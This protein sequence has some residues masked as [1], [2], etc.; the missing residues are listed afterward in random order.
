MNTAEALVKL[1]E[2][3]GV[4]HIFGHPGEQILPVYRA[5]QDSSIEH[6]L[7]RHEQAGAHAASMYACSTGK[8]SVCISTASPGALNFVM[9]AATSYK[10]HV[11]ILI[12][13]GDNP[14]SERLEDRFQTFDLPSVFENV[15]VK[16]YS[17]TNAKEAIHALKEAIEIFNKE[18]TGPIHINLPKDVLNEEAPSNYLDYPVEYDPNY[19]Y[20]QLNLLKTIISS[21]KK[22]FIIAGAG[23]VWSGACLKLKEFAE[24]NNIPIATTYTARGVID[25]NN[26]INLGMVGLRG[27]AMSNYAYLNSDLILVLGSRLSE[28]TTALTKDL[29]DFQQKIVH[30]NID[31]HVLKGRLKIHGDVSH[32]LDELNEIE[33]DSYNNKQWLKEIKLHDEKLLVEG[34]DDTRSMPLRP[35]VAI[36]TVIGKMDDAYIMSDAG[37]HAT[38]TMLYARPNK[39]GKFLYSGAL[40]P[41]GM[42][43]P[44]SIGISLAHPDDKVLVITG[45]GSFQMCIQELA[46]I[47]EY[48]LPIVICVI[49][50]NQLAIIR[51]WEEMISPDFRYQVD[52]K[53]PDFLAIVKGY[54]IDGER[55]ANI[56]QLEKALLKAK[57]SNGPYFIEVLTRQE[58]IPLSEVKPQ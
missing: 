42:G 39:F 1:L 40:C 50:N 25:E 38:W 53:N 6:I 44:G 47:A 55:V 14:Y 9:A 12:L 22:P 16:N 7:V 33:I 3:A 27:T 52:L 54:G 4:K 45:D 8:F 41:M 34:E 46:T 13:T 10:D 26:P 20:N 17:P 56:E 24:K 57:D 31:D 15:T 51:Q 36:K 37:S 23:V 32:V 29:N 11:P 19:N 58:N 5:L 21:S 30:V 28:R 2:N 43:L 49:N 18:P 35:Q 48:N